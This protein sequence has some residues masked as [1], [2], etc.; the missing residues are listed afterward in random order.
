VYRFTESR[1]NDDPVAVLTGYQGYIHADAYPGYDVLFDPERATEVACWAHVRRK[2]TDAEPTEPDL[3]AD[4][5]DRI[6]QLYAI[7]RQAKEAEMDPDAVRELRQSASV[8]ILQ[9]SVEVGVTRR[10]PND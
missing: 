8:P 10:L 6:G 7:E 2:F 4:V 9:V 5:I 3:A 1:S